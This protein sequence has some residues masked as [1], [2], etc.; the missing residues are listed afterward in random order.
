MIGIEEWS[1]LPLQLCLLLL[2]SA[3]D[4]QIIVLY[5]K[6]CHAAMMVILGGRRR[7]VGE[8]SCPLFP[9]LPCLLCLFLSHTHLSCL[10]YCQVPPVMPSNSATGH[11]ASI[12][13]VFCGIASEPNSLPVRTTNRWACHVAHL[14]CLPHSPIGDLTCHQ[15]CQL[16]VSYGT[17][18][19]L[20]LP[21][22]S[23]LRSLLDVSGYGWRPGC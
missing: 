4:P 22:L 16:H 7:H 13:H 10:L 15:V 2:L 20:Q 3:A 8:A 14:P 5:I 18:C 9:S 23:C 12:N 6:D 21:H 1:R 19:L 11:A 17:C